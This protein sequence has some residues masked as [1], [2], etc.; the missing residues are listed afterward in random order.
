MFIPYGGNFVLEGPRGR[1][2]LREG[3]YHYNI[4]LENG[5]VCWTMLKIIGKCS[6][7]SVGE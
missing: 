5:I 1:V 6:D 3:V 7:S 4:T 2:N